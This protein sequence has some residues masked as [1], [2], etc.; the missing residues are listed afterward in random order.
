MRWALITD[1]SVLAPQGHVPYDAASKQLG[2]RKM[3]YTVGYI[4]GDRNSTADKSSAQE[5]LKF[6]EDMEDAGVKV[7]FIRSPHGAEIG[8][9]ELEHVAKHEKAAIGQE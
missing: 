7:L 6:L 9:K 2:E 4:V 5:T 3:A 1:D 8:L